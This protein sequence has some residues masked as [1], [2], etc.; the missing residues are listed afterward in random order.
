MQTAPE[1]VLY[2]DNRF[3]SLHFSPLWLKI[4]WPEFST[5]Y[6]I[7]IPKQCGKSGAFFHTHRPVARIFPF[8][9]LYWTVSSC[10]AGTVSISVGPVCDTLLYCWHWLIICWTNKRKMDKLFAA[11]LMTVLSEL[12][13]V[14]VLVRK[15][16][17]FL[18][19]LAKFCSLTKPKVL[20]SSVFF[21]RKYPTHFLVECKYHLK[22]WVY[23]SHFNGSTT[24][25]NLIEREMRLMR[26]SRSG[27]GGPPFLC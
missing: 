2:V 3:L 22:T 18:L 23:R 15:A 17:H 9:F 5:T 7:K 6:K 1:T 12:L 21:Y 26:E 19:Y 11:W 20:L 24:V 25:N 16:S 14:F 10:K 13:N 27:S 4:D 8:F